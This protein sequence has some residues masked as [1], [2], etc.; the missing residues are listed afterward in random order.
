MLELKKYSEVIFHDTRSDAKLE[1]KVTCGL[2]N[3]RW[4]I[5]ETFTRSLASLEIG[6]FMGYF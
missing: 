5:W 6:T 4:G 3:G 1:E 2:V